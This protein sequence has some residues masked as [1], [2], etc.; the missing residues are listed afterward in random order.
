MDDGKVNAMGPAFVTGFPAAWRDATA[1]GAPVVL[2]GNA[3]VFCAG[4][5]LKALVHLDAKQLADF[6]RGFMRVFRDVLAHPRPVVAAV[7]G[8]ALAGGAVLALAS[9]HRLVSP[10][11][12]LGLVEVPVG[13]PFPPP[14]VDLARL[15]LPPQEL[16]DALL[17]GA[18][19]EDADCVARGWAQALVPRER[20]LDEAIALARELGAYSRPAYA[21]A[22]THPRAA[23]V[24]AFDR[25]DGEADAWAEQLL[26][27]ETKT[28]L[29]ATLA[30]LQRR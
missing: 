30:R 13:I 5:D 19:R 23:L 22:K 21:S 17:R 8:A 7:D 2:A 3:K 4:L 9:D 18:V 27:D 10:A 15:T 11:A 26:S 16:P 29:A 25:F 24:A 1:G 28:A 12:R 20:L 6:G 14:V